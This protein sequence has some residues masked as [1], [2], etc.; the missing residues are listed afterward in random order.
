MGLFRNSL[1]SNVKVEGRGYHIST[2]SPLITGWVLF[3][4]SPQVLT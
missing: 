1:L 2:A 4:V 3:L